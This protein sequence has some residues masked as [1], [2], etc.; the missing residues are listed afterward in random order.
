MC[1]Y[2]FQFCENFYNLSSYL[3]CHER[4]NVLESPIS[5]SMLLHTFLSLHVWTLVGK[6]VGHKT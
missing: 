4:I 1:L 3:E 5:N 6:Y 2:F